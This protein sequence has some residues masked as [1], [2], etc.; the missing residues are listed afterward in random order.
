MS[1]YGRREEAEEEEEEKEE[2]KQEEEE[3]KQGGVVAVDL[4]ILRENISAGIVK[5]EGQVTEQV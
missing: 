3:G 4:R 5:K 2:R 1:V